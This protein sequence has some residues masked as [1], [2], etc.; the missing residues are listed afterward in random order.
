MPIL[1]FFFQLLVYAPVHNRKQILVTSILVDLYAKVALRTFFCASEN[2]FS[3]Q[4]SSSTIVWPSLM[5]IF[6]SSLSPV[7]NV[8]LRGY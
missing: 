3:E 6:G 7:C 4:W 8:H 1:V 2:S 5:P